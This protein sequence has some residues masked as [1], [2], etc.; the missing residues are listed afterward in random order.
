MGTESGGQPGNKNAQKHGVFALRDNGE[1]AMTAEQRKTAGQLKRQLESREGVVDALRDAATQTV[2]LASVAQQYCVDQHQ[3]GRP[4]DDI[5]LLRS[6]PAFWNS[7]GRA[8][9]TYLDS[10]PKDSPD[11]IDLDELRRQ[12]GDDNS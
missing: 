4:L 8:L 5:A 2:I 10:L 9:K 7:A 1:R 3:A 11:A 12:Y 6:L